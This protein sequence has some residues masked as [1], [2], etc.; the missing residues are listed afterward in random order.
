MTFEESCGRA[1]AHFEDTRNV[2]HVGVAQVGEW[3]V[4]VEPWAA[5]PATHHDDPTVAGRRGRERGRD[6]QRAMSREKSAEIRQWVKAHGLPLSERGRI[7]F[8]VVEWSEDPRGTPWSASPSPAEALPQAV[9]V[10]RLLRHR[11]RAA[12]T[13]VGTMARARMPP[14]R[15]RAG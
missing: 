5:S 15:A 2:L 13:T 14:P 7:D 4:A 10:R 1:R 6:G 12:A 8:T 9:P 11:A 3:S